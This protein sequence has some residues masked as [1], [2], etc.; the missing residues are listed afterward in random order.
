MTVKD[1]RY[2][3][4]GSHF[5]YKSEKELFDRLTECGALREGLTYYSR[6]VFEPPLLEDHARATV[7]MVSDEYKKTSPYVDYGRAYEKLI[8]AGDDLLEILNLWVVKHFGEH[9]SSKVYSHNVTAE[10]FNP[11]RVH[12]V[13]PCS[14]KQ[15]SR[16]IVADD[17]FKAACAWAEKVGI[18]EACDV[19]VRSLYTVGKET[20]LRVHCSYWVTSESDVAQAG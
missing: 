6:E 15:E 19:V 8:E 12:L 20:K 16:R 10:Q 17:E 11:Y 4:D 7:D 9:F 13:W 14:A 2:S 3:A 1:V 18:T 5:D